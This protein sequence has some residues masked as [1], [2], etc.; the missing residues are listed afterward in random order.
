M[1]REELEDGAGGRRPLARR[2]STR[3]ERRV[4]REEPTQ[5]FRSEDRGATWNEV[6]GLMAMPQDI[7]DNWWSPVSGVGHVRN[8]FVHPDDSNTLY[9][10][11]E[12]GGIVRSFDRGETWEDVS[13]GIDYLD[14][15]LVYG[16]PTDASR[17]YVSS[18]RL[19]Q[20]R[21]SGQGLGP[22]QRFQPR[23]L[24]RLH[25]STAPGRGPEPDDA[26][27]HGRS[28]PWRYGTG[29]TAC[30]RLARP[31]SAARTTPR[32]G[33]ASSRGCR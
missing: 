13:Q 20:E 32:R 28:L 22:C 19:L 11:L 10:A 15:H 14:I 23:L 4:R 17:Y 7:Q 16:H 21:R 2:R 33:S 29:P 30:A 1:M 12:H 25:L 26:D 6:A 8:I 3:R 18:A 9:L 5:L 27:R 24:P 31:S